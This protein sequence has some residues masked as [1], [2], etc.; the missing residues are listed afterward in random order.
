M[1]QKPNNSKRVTRQSTPRKSRNN[2]V[3]LLRPAS[4]SMLFRTIILMGVVIA[5]IVAIVM[6]VNEPMVYSFLWALASY[7]ALSGSRFDPPFDRR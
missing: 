1:K 5:G 2:D 4:I 3:P 7:A 6:R